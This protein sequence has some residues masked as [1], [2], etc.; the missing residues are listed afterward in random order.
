MLSSSLQRILT[1]NDSDFRRYVGEGI[2]I[3]TP[4]ALLNQGAV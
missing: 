2:E 1:L 3:A 4:E